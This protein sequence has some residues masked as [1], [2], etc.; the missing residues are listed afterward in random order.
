MNDFVIANTVMQLLIGLSLFLASHFMGRI[1]VSKKNYD[2]YFWIFMLLFSIS[3][4]LYGYLLYKLFPT[5]VDSYNSFLSGT[6]MI[7]VVGLLFSEKGYRKFSD[8]IINRNTVAAISVLLVAVFIY[9]SAIDSEDVS[10]YSLT[11]LQYY[12]STGQFLSVAVYPMILLTAL[13]LFLFRYSMSISVFAFYMLCQII[14]DLGHGAKDVFWLAKYDFDDIVSSLVVFG[15][16]IISLIILLK[17]RKKYY[18]RV[19]I[20]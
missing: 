4:S 10:Y 7:S 8:T 11:T 1:F 17:A 15:F 9:F 19:K 18:L 12:G 2:P 20:K 16:H 14:D 6:I 5:S 3:P 13:I